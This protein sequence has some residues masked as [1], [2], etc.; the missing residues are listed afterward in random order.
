MT[1]SST[2]PRVLAYL[3]A[4]A[5]IL[6]LSDALVYRLRG[7]PQDSVTVQRYYALHKTKEK[8]NFVFADPQAQSCARALFPHSGNT[9]CWYLRRHT[10]QR[11]DYE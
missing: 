9:P 5:L 11:I 4:A 6:Y 7:Q 10:E 2:T 3:V 8:T 1:A